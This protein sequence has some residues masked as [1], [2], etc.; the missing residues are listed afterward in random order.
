[1]AAAA[2]EGATSAAGTASEM[3]EAMAVMGAAMR[4]GAM[5]AAAKK[6][7]P[8]AEKEKPAARGATASATAAAATV[9]EAAAAAAL[10]AQPMG[11]WSRRW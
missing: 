10:A 8:A 2:W 7:E 6:V 4:G 3:V 11:L 1:M 9:T 5:G